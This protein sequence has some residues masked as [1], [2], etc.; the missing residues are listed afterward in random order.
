MLWCLQTLF[1]PQNTKKNMKP[2]LPVSETASKRAISS[3]S[4]FLI[5]FVV[6]IFGLLSRS[7]HAIVEFK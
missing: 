7:R 6:A 4:M 5:I 2:T 1:Y 3:N